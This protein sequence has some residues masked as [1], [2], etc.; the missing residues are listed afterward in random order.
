VAEDSQ[1]GIGSGARCAQAGYVHQELA[2]SIAE[3]SGNGGIAHFGDV[4]DSAGD[5]PYF[6]LPSGVSERV[7]YACL[8]R[9]IV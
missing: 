9:G 5:E 3:L 4:D 6:L 7:L 1:P 2:G 8:N